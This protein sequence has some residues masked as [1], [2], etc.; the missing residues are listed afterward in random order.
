MSLIS[1]S[2]VS[3]QFDGRPI[4]NDVT[5]NVDR[6]ARIGLIGRNGSGKSTLL[7]ILNRELD[8]SPPFPSGAVERTFS[9]G[10]GFLWELRGNSRLGMGINHSV[11][12]NRDNVQGKDDDSTGFRASAVWDL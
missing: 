9:F 3:Q 1:L 12:R 8:P 11:M 6:G 7:R 5:L 2:R 4:L 10:L